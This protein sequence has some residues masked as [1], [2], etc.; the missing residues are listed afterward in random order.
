MQIIHIIRNKKNALFFKPNENETKKKEELKPNK[1]KKVNFLYYQFAYHLQEYIYHKNN[2]LKYEPLNS[3]IIS[4]FI[5]FFN[6]FLSLTGN[7]I[8][9]RIFFIFNKFREK[10]LGEETLFR[11]KIYL[12][13]LEK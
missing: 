3:H 7:K 2:E 10:I 13:H 12:Y 6:F 1:N 8:K 11:T 9:K 4:R 5:N